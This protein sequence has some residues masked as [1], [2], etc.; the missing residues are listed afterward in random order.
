MNAACEQTILNT[1]K[2]LT[3]FCMAVYK[4]RIKNNRNKL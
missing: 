1:L 2:N 4:H 3:D